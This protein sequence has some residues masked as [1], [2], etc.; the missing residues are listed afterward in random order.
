MLCLHEYNVISN[1]NHDFLILQMSDAMD[2]AQPL[3]DIIG[4]IG[5]LSLFRFAKKQELIDTLGLHMYTP[6]KKLH[7][8]ST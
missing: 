5:G 6:G 8:H 3:E 4:Y 1:Y 7:S 2:E